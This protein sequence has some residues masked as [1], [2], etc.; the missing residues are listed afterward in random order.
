MLKALVSR[1][2][3]LILFD[4]PHYVTELHGCYSSRLKSTLRAEER[5]RGTFI[6]HPTQVELVLHLAFVKV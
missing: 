4:F 2:P 3:P 6:R 5:H 1:G